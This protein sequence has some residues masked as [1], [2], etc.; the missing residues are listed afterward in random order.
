MN[1]PDWTPG[2]WEALPGDEQVFIERQNIAHVGFSAE[3]GV[4][5]TP[6]VVA[7]QAFRDGPK[8]SHE[9]NA[10][11]IAAA[12]Y[13]FQALHEMT[14]VYWG[15]DDDRNGDGREPPPQVIVRARLAL[16]KARGQS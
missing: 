12:P 16:A 11:L 13:L 2:H 7:G 3:A 5:A 14:D 4:D 15:V 8:G 9:A 10:R 6:F 1:T